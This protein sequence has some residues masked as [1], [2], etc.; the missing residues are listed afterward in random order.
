M[1]EQQGIDLSTVSGSG[2]NGRVVKADIEAYAGG[3]AP[4]TTAPVATPAAAPA[5]SGAVSPNPSSRCRISI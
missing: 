4:T 2:P 3:A 5:I 1:A